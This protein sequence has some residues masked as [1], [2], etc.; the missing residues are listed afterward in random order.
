M[1]VLA[2]LSTEVWDVDGEVLWLRSS[3]SGW[4]GWWNDVDDGGGQRDKN[5][6]KPT[7]ASHDFDIADSGKWKVRIK[8]DKQTDR[9]KKVLIYLWLTCTKRSFFAG[10]GDFS[11]PT[12]PHIGFINVFIYFGIFCYN[13]IYINLVYIIGIIYNIIIL[14]ILIIADAILEI[15]YCA[16]WY[17]T[18]IYWPNINTLPSKCQHKENVW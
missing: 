12:P 6:S 5:S 17:W 8:R 13:Y 14:I 11:I 3:S 10:S 18:G 9:L 16:I 15:R 4:W 1:I 2:I 7:F